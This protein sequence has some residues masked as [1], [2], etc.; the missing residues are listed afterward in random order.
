MQPNWEALRQAV[1]I[2]I[3]ATPFMFGVLTLF[4]GAIH[5]LSRLPSHSS[6]AP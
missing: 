5:L 1:G 2:L 4:A 3:V 6:K